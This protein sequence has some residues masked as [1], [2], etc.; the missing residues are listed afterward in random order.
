MISGNHHI[1]ILVLLLFFCLHAN[2]PAYG[3]LLAADNN[4]GST[5]A[6]GSPIV[7]TS[8][9]SGAS[10][11]SEDAEESPDPHY[12]NEADPDAEIRIT[13]STGLLQFYQNILKAKVSP[14]DIF[15]MYKHSPSEITTDEDEENVE[16]YEKEHVKFLAAL[17]NMHKGRNEWLEAFQDLSLIVNTHPN[18]G[19]E[20][21]WMML[22][23]GA[24][25]LQLD[26]INRLDRRPGVHSLNGFMYA[27]GIRQN[28]SQAKAVLHYTLGALHD[29]PISL[30]ALGYRFWSGVSVPASCERA[31][32]FYKRVA[33]KVSLYIRF[34]CF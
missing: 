17:K 12:E 21:A 1:G 7:K 34:V 15:L 30:M 22:M 11:S 8:S 18:A 23:M 10:S 28:V 14:N 9:K 24:D 16:G 26:G 2:N 6:P 3:D 31:L 25:E 27:T 5:T 4:I 19:V 13:T 20:F 33:T 29:E 32:H